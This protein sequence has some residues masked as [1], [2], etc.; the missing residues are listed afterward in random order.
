MWIIN[1]LL[2]LLFGERSDAALIRDTASLLP[3]H[4][5]YV[6][7]HTTSLSHFREPAVRAAVHETK[8]H[9]NERAA[10]LLAELLVHQLKAVPLETVL[11]PLPLSKKR[12]RERG[13]NQVEWVLKMACAHTGHIYRTNILK[14]VRHTAPQTSLD[15][16]ARVKNMQDAFTTST[17]AQNITADTHLLIIDDVCTTGATLTAAKEA[18]GQLDLASVQCVA[19]AH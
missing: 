16:A 11:I 10:K 8:F 6:T 4:A 1:R 18:F 9:E 3:Y 2:K 14:R 17:N 19:L 7:G 13:Y 5:P 15:K 12:F